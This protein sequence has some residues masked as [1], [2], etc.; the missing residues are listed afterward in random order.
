[1]FQCK[2]IGSEYESVTGLILNASTRRPRVQGT[3]IKHNIDYEIL[4]QNEEYSIVQCYAT[5]EISDI[6]ENEAYYE[7]LNAFGKC[8]VQSE[9]RHDCILSP[10]LSCIVAGTSFV[11]PCW[12]LDLKRKVN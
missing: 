5:T 1:M 6:D 9:F 10:I 4:V 8:E 3:G 12:T 7:Q 2:L 11:L